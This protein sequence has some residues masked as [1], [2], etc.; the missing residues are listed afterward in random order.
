M[1][2]IER[3]VYSL[4]KRNRRVKELLKYIYQL[5]YY[6]FALIKPKINSKF[7]VIASEKGYFGFHDRPSINAI[8][9]LICHEHKE[10]ELVSEDNPV[11]IFIKNIHSGRMIYEI[12]TSCY[13]A[14]QGSLVTWMDN[15]RIIFNN[16][17]S[18]NP[19][20]QIV[21]I[22]T[23]R[24]RCIDGHYFSV[25]S[26]NK[27]LVMVNFC[28]FGT[29]L[30]GYGYNIDYNESIIEDSLKSKPSG[31]D[32]SSL[33]IYDLEKSLI[34]N[35][36]TLS[37]CLKKSTGLDL[38]GYFYFSHSKFNK[39]SSGFYFLLRSSNI[40]RNTSQLFYFSI[41]SLDLISL[42][43]HGMVS[44]LTW[45][46]NRTILAYSNSQ[47]SNADAYHVY[48][49]INGNV[50]DVFSSELYQDGHPVEI[51]DDIFITDTYADKLRRQYLYYCDVKNNE[52]DIILDVFTPFKF[53]NLTRVDLHPRISLCGNYLTID[54]SF[55]GY[56][57]QLVLEIKDFKNDD[58]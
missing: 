51:R 23:G 31:S 48:D 25:S 11:R 26:C 38:D 35:E 21:N 1:K 37:S 17:S 50:N 43:T 16:S 12:F 57:E 19:V 58:Q 47:K 46:D 33:K 10:P 6:P 40:N 9:E 3:L 56:R 15:D 55:K 34:I 41:T 4:V 49:V 13:S 30:S 5:M 24:V 18:G 22:R 54:T 28:R 7:K 44:H 52:I 53:M 32:L 36:I 27:F 20:T 45:L 39:D 8:G 2:S 14:Q 29:G 42:D